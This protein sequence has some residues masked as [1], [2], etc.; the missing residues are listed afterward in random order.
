MHTA[1]SKELL[2]LITMVPPDYKQINAMFKDCS[3]SKEELADVGIDLVD[4]CFMVYS[5]EQDH[6]GNYLYSNILLLLLNGLD[7]NMLGEEGCA[8]WAAHCIDTPGVAGRVIRLLI[9]FGGDINTVDED[10]YDPENLFEYLDEKIS[11][12]YDIGFDQSDFDCW[13]VC[14]G[15]GGKDKFGQVPIKM[16]N[17]HSIEELKEFERFDC[18]MTR[19]GFYDE[20]NGKYF[21]KIID[22]KTREIVALY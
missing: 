18:A 5:S 11:D 2:N 10:E 17:G 16:V 21:M 3:F 19:D 9:E 8:L 22:K 13:L 14:L 20:E 7:P 1:N 15:Y 12:W 6:S 4:K